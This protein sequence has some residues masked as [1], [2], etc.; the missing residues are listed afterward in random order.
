MKRHLLTIS[1]ICLTVLIVL[2]GDSS[3]TSVCSKSASHYE[4]KAAFLIKFT[5]FIK[6]PETAFKDEPNHFVLGILGKN[7]FQ[8]MLDPFVGKIIQE[9]PFKIK[10]FN[11]IEKISDISGIQ[12]LFVSQSE[13]PHF[14]KIFDTIDT[15]GMLTISDTPGFIR[16]GGTIAFVNQGKRI[17]FEINRVS[18]KRAGLKISSD[19]LQLATHVYRK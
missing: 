10:Y 6:W 1:I 2:F 19:L 13:A 9:R 17:S 7:V 16:Y 18:E 4:I 14:Q 11:G 5:D 8:H 15:T 12:M 3:Y